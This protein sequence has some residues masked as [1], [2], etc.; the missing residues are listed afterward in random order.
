MAGITKIGMGTSYHPSSINESY[1]QKSTTSDS[2]AKNI[3][4]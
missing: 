2:K 1:K 4:S 3:L